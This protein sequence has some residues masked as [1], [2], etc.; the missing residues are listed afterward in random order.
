LI[1]LHRISPHLSQSIHCYTQLV[2]SL[3]NHRRVNVQSYRVTSCPSHRS[4]HD[5]NLRVNFRTIHRSICMS[6][7]RI[8][9]HLKSEQTSPRRSRWRTSLC[10]QQAFGLV[11]THDSS[12]PPV[13]T[14]SDVTPCPMQAIRWTR[15]GALYGS[16]RGMATSARP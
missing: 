12:S 11:S 8:Q 4:I 9:S 7:R 5:Y 15:T 6:R 13:Q 16:P 3:K 14:C 10:L 2:D 1:T